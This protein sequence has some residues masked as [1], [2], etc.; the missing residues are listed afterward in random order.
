MVKGTSVYY[1][2]LHCKGPGTPQVFIIRGEGGGSFVF[3]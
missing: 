3:E 1:Y 2:D